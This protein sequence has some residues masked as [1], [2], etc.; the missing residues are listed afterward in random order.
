MIVFCTNI[1][2]TQIQKIKET[3]QLRQSLFN[4]V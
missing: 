1:V 4:P 2:L 3:A